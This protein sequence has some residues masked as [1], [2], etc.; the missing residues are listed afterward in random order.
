MDGRRRPPHLRHR[1]HQPPPPLRPR[2]G[3][4]HRPARHSSALRRRQSGVP[5]PPPAPPP[6]PPAPDPTPAPTPEPTPAPTPVP[7]PAPT[8]VPIP[9]EVQIFSQVQPWWERL[10]VIEHDGSL[11]HS[12]SHLAQSYL[13]L[14]NGSLVHADAPAQVQS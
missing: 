3:P 8:P 12:L 9:S 1:G 14:S 7:T 6:P 4:A 13:E 2:A 11:L 5:A 10:M